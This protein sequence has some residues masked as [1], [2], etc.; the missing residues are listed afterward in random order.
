VSPWNS[1]L[2]DLTK[3][4]AIIESPFQAL[5]LALY[6][7]QSATQRV[8]CV[9]PTRGNTQQTQLV[10][11]ELERMGLGPARV[12]D[13]RG[14][15]TRPWV[16]NLVRR[17]FHEAVIRERE[18]NLI[19]GN[20]FSVAGWSL[21]ARP[22]FGGK[23]VI[24]DDGVQTLSIARA[25]SCPRVSHFPKVQSS[26]RILAALH[27]VRL[28]HEA[29]IPAQF[30]TTFNH[31]RLTSA[32]DSVLEVDWKLLGKLPVKNSKPV[33]AVEGSRFALVIGSPLEGL[34][35]RIRRIFENLVEKS[36][37][38]YLGENPSPLFL[39]VPHRR[40]ARLPDFVH[41]ERMK[42]AQLNYPIEHF[43]HANRQRIT[44]VYSFHSS[45][46]ASSKFILGSETPLFLG[47]VMAEDFLSGLDVLNL[48]VD[49]W[50]R[51]VSS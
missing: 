47:A 21:T 41:E 18:F 19:L 26:D 23:V 24:L 30:Y 13:V 17:K 51:E 40:E 44:S 42:V 8:Q 29:D 5:N 49:W 37:T 11:D 3:N 43:V 16:N 46:L 1:N 2:G 10:T 25:S 48:Y 35:P 7:E 27:A 12:V 14:E 34:R 9:V 32:S 28:A 15:G 4:L 20:Y 31:E 6:L 38:A 33:A 36:F 50:N 45:A 39:Y 22:N